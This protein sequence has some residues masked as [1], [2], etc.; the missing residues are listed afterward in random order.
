MLKIA[1]LGCGYWGPNLLRNFQSLSECTV[2]HVV[3]SSSERK[4]FIHSN[5]PKVS[6]E[7]KLEEILADDKIDAIVIATPAKFH[8]EQAKLALLAGKHVFVEKPLA[9][10]VYEV[11]ELQ[12]ISEKFKLICMVGHTFLFNPAVRFVK[13]MI[14][15]EDLGKLYYIYSQRLNL[16]RIR[17]DVNALWNF[18]PHDVSIIQYWLNEIAPISIS[19]RGSSFVQNGIEDVSFLNL[20]YPTGVMANI[21]VSWLDPNKTRKITIVGSKKMIIYDD[22]A[23]NKIAVFDKGI[24]VVAKLGQQMDFDDLSILSFNHRSGNVFFPKI[25]WIEPLRTETQHFIDCIKGKTS[26]ITGPI[27]AKKVVDILEKAK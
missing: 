12:L 16:G 15:N 4:K 25:D 11:E 14:E 17:S 23:T 2:T 3:E 24:D 20:T 10:K 13:S 27:H 5:F 18:A 8:F 21:H 1:Q 22:L 19:H 7:L 6:T 26:C 9:Q